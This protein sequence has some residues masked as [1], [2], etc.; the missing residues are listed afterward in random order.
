MSDILLSGFELIEQVGEGGMGNVWKARQLS[1]DRIVAVKLLPSRFSRDPESIRQIVQEART[2]ARLKHPGI[3]QVYDASEDNGNYYFV[4]E[5]VNGYNVGEWLKRKKIIPVQDALVVVESVVAAL[6]YAWRSAGLIHCDIKPENIM[7]DQDGTIKVADLGLSLTQDSDLSQP[8]DEIAGTPGY[9]SPEQVQGEEKLDCR[10]DIYALGCCLYQMVTGRRPFVELS[11]HE[12][13]EAQVTSQ[14]PDPRDIV[15]GIPAPVCCL[16]ERMLVKDRNARLNDWQAVLA[17]LHRVQKRLMPAGAHP[18]PGASTMQR[19]IASKG[20]SREVDSGKAQVGSPQKVSRMT[21]VLLVLAAISAGFFLYFRSL[22]KSRGNV[23]PVLPAI[24]VTAIPPPAKAMPAQEEP[25]SPSPAVREQVSPKM[26]VKPRR[27]E[28][29][30]LDEALNEIKR[31]AAD[32]ESDGAFKEGIRWLENY[33][34]RWATETASNRFVLA[35]EFRA[36]INGVNAESEWLGVKKEIAG[37][38]LSGKYTAARAQLDQVMN[39][40]KFQAHADEMKS[41]TEVLGAVGSLNDKILA[42]FASDVGKLVTIGLARGTFTGKVVEIRDRK[43]V[44]QT[45]DGMAK[46]DI[47]LEDLSMDERMTRLRRL[48]APEVA[49]VLGV[50][51]FNEKRL[52][53]AREMLSKAGSGWGPYLA[54]AAQEANAKQMHDELAADPACLAFA[55][56]LTKAGIQEQPIDLLRWRQEIDG[57]RMSA[58]EAGRVDRAMEGFLMSYGQS[59]FAEKN[60]GL[61][62]ALQKACGI[63]LESAPAGTEE[64]QMRPGMEGRGR[65]FRKQWQ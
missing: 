48:E 41:L 49:L 26:A 21:V 47:R 64:H 15:P 53:D 25:V 43:V 34:G 60:A 4:M 19:R 51:A 6:D 8:S 56:L 20:E 40:P 2:A 1:L 63:A 37:L 57:R 46:V 61:I 36:R 23:H 50:T 17:D 55:K 42:T 30:S 58:E 14:I 32:Y 7:V 10:T 31:V 13:M 44:C 22:E 12:A 29:Q 16:I 5:Y 35:R 62:L 59:D 24:P 39:Q 11:D 38:L 28:G 54:Q 18:Q 9:I 27:Q 33:S 65:H 3:V 45:P 52:D